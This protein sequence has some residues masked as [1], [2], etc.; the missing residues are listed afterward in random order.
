[1]D[2]ATEQLLRELR[3]SPTDLAKLVERVQRCPGR[4]VA[5]P[6]PALARWRKDDPDAWERVHAWLT[7]HGLR[8]VVID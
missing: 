2:R 6:G 8:L 1:M 5:I 3:G 7:N 4:V